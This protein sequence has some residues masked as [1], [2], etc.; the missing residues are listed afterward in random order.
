VTVIRLASKRSLEPTDH[1]VA[2]APG[3]CRRWRTPSGLL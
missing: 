2:S 1:P 3:K